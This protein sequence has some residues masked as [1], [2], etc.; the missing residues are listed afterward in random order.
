MSKKEVYKLVCSCGAT[1]DFNNKPTKCPKCRTMYGGTIRVAKQEKR[2]FRKKPVERG[3]DIR[4]WWIMPAFI[5]SAFIGY[6]MYMAG[7]LWL[8][9]LVIAGLITLRAL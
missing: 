1:F 6:G 8:F 2:D 3:L 5:I 4:D 7:L 9:V